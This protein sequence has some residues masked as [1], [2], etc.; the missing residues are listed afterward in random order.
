MSKLSEVARRYNCALG[1]IA[2]AKGCIKSLPEGAGIAA[3]VSQADALKSL[4]NLRKCL[5]SD[6]QSIKLKIIK[7]RKILK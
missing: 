3:M 4:D 2:M 5:S 6:Y 7:E 1:Q